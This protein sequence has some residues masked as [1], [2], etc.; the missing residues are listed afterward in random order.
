MMERFRPRAEI[1]RML[2]EMDRLLTTPL[3]RGR[4]L[5]RLTPFR[6]AIDLYETPDALIVKALVPGAK[7]DDIHV[8]LE[9]TTLTIR[10]TYG[11]TLP[12][13]EETEAT[14]HFREAVSGEFT[15]TLTLPAV[16][17]PDAVTATVEQGVLTLKMP[18]SAETRAKHI[19][20]HE[21]GAL[22]G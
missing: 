3:R 9:H 13:D 15:E 16:V 7:P 18:K 19:P 8:S 12:E 14:W 5:P 10:G 1:E 2:D 17:D 20:V 11:Y 4:F 6:P 21:A 22:V